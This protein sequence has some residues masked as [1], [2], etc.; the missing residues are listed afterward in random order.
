MCTPIN[1]ASAGVGVQVLDLPRLP[2][3]TDQRS[4][5]PHAADM[6]MVVQIGAYAPRVLWSAAEIKRRREARGWTQQQLADALGASRRAV[7]SWEAGESTPQGRFFGQLENVLGG[8]PSSD[9][10]GPLLRDADF[11]TTV[12]HL[13]ELYNDAIRDR[14]TP[15]LRVDESPIQ[16][17]VEGHD[18]IEGP[19]QESPAPAGRRKGKRPDG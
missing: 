4:L 2:P 14:I 18:F 15:V 6:S 7:I 19:P 13:V 17:Q 9:E 5:P 10:E 11:A 8:D 16:P 12:N 3:V 1:L